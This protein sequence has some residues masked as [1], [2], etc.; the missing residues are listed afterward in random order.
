MADIFRKK[1]LDKLSSPEQLDKMIIINSPMVWLALVGGGIIIAVTLIWGVLGRVPITETGKGVLLRHGTVGSVYSATQGVIT[2]TNVKSGDMVKKG[3][4]LY[5]VQSKETEQAVL[6]L[7]ER[8]QAVEAVTYNSINDIVTSDNQSLLNLKNQKSSLA[9]ENT[10]NEASL[11]TLQREYNRILLEVNDKKAALDIAEKMYYGNIAADDSS[12]AAYEYEVAYSE[13]QAAESAYQSA[14][15]QVTSASGSTPGK[16]AIEAAKVA[17]AQAQAIY[18]EALRTVYKPAI[19]QANNEVIAAS[20][21]FENAKSEWETAVSNGTCSDTTPL[22]GPDASNPCHCTKCTDYYNANYMVKEKKEILKRAKEM[23][24]ICEEYK[25]LLA[26]KSQLEQLQSA[27]S[28]LNSANGKVEE[29]KRQRDEKKAV[30]DSKKEVYDA[31]IASVASDQ[32]RSTESAN[33]YSRALSEYNTVKATLDGIEREIKTMEVTVGVTGD[34]QK[35]QEESLEVQFENTKAAILD[36]LKQQLGNYKVLAEGQKIV[37]PID[38]VVY[39][40]F[41]TNG[42][43]VGVDFEVAR[44]S[45]QEEVAQLEAVY[46]LPLDSGKN[47]KEGMKV[48]IYPNTLPKEEYGHMTGTVVSVADYVT[49]YADLF[50]R[51]G[52]ETM[53]NTFTKEGAVVEITCQIEVDKSTVSGYAWSSKKGGEAYLTEGTL[54]SGNFVVEDVPPITMLIPKLKEKFHL[55]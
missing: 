45:S 31:Y 32:A 27:E 48:N 11:L 39:S 30:Y 28:T 40:T 10:A 1:S 44:I 29:L 26:A 22:E 2:K 15:A 6:Q 13:Y 14:L 8:I 55:E 41:V 24:D 3:D 49:S 18:D 42:S 20:E 19:E 43:S 16:S 34:S 12:V 54:L 33:T 50:T 9:L 25:N 52:D 35:V 4:V 46:F 53:A 7:E 17:V 51:V 37:A 47:I 5:E 36:Q 38:G 21:A 23:P